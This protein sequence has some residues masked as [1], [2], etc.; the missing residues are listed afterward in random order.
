MEI[1][2]LFLSKTYIIL[3]VLEIEFH[4][5]FNLYDFVESTHCDK[6]TQNSSFKHKKINISEQTT[7][8]EHLKLRTNHFKNKTGIDF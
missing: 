3:K 2:N 6:E 8:S 4:T 1:S 7:N 5:I